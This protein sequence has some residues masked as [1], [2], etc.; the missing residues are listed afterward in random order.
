MHALCFQNHPFFE[1]FSSELKV[2]HESGIID[3]MLKR[4]S[5]TSKDCVAPNQ[6]LGRENTVVPF[7]ILLS[8]CGLSLVCLVSEG[9]AAGMVLFSA[10]QSGPEEKKK[11]GRLRSEQLLLWEE[12]KSLLREKTYLSDDASQ[13]LS[14]LKALLNNNPGIL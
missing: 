14:K 9:M 2:L 6:A 1:L 13:K 3:R 4:S 11:L 5:S 10:D 12:C 8:G 7:L